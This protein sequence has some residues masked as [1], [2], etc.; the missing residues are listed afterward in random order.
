MLV[1]SMELV[2]DI[3]PTAVIFTTTDGGKGWTSGRVNQCQRG[4][5]LLN[6]VSCAS[7]TKCVVVGGGSDPTYGVES[8][9]LTSSD[10]GRTWTPRMVPSSMSAWPRERFV[11]DG[12]DLRGDGR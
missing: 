1:G 3:P 8:T 5:D 7:P 2:G 4:A 10:G 9:I 6:A 12:L 11:P